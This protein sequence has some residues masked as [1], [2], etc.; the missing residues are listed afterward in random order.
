MDEPVNHLAPIIKGLVPENSDGLMLFGSAA[1]GDMNANSDVDV[2]VV[3]KGKSR[4]I[5]NGKFNISF[6]SRNHLASMAELGS[7]F[8]RHLIDDG[9]V[10]DDSE[11]V[12]ADCLT[13]YNRPKDYS[14]FRAELQAVLPLLDVTEMEFESRSK[15]WLDVA[16]FCLRSEV[17][18][19]AD[20]HSEL[21]FSLA[22]LEKNTGWEDVHLVRIARSVDQERRWGVFKDVR[23]ALERC[24][25][26]QAINP[27]GTV[28]A[29]ATN[30]FDEHPLVLSLALRIIL[31]ANVPINYDLL[32]PF[33]WV[34]E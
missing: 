27:Y 25:K 1:R 11:G 32:S 7:L 24:L 9:I 13:K 31:G 14:H 26:G 2:L 33:S 16:V 3:L 34:S 22:K 5:R 28:E 21:C 4:T 15:S 23:N 19:R 18:I 29:Y 30:V 20:E 17:Y 6:Y 12:I 10:I 8:V